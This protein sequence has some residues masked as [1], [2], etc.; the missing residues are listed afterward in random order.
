MSW[1]IFEKM[2]QLRRK[3]TNL[4]RRAVLRHEFVYYL[5]RGLYFAKQGGYNSQAKRNFNCA[6][7]LFPNYAKL[8]FLRAQVYS[9]MGRS[10]RAIKDYDRAIYI[11]PIYAEAY[12]KRGRILVGRNTYRGIEDFSSAIFLDPKFVDAYNLRGAIYL[13]IGLYDRAIK[14]L[15]RAIE[16]DPS[17]NTAYACLDCGMAYLMKELYDE[18]IEEFSRAISRGLN[19]N[20]KVHTK[21]GETYLRKGLYDRAIED[22]SQIIENYSLRYRADRI[23]I[24]NIHTYRG[25][26]YML[27]GLLDLAIEDYDHAISIYKKHSSA[28]Y[29]RGLCF[30]KKGDLESARR[31][32]ERARDLGDKKSINQLRKLQ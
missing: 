7:Y 15:S 12:Y 13:E 31:S 26:A 8:Y 21:R 32:F 30:K 20:K 25:N 28:F 4:S 14:D 9:Q 6:I 24:S 10:N 29:F 2:D 5:N 1:K 19:N 18:A 11:D 16:L 23:E 3:V 17:A 22:F 27:K